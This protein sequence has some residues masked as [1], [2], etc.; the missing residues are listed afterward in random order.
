MAQPLQSVISKTFT[1]MDA[2]TQKKAQTE[3]CKHKLPKRSVKDLE[4]LQGSIPS[5]A[6]PLGCENDGVVKG[7]NE[8]HTN[9]W[10]GGGGGRGTGRTAPEKNTIR[11]KIE[12]FK[13]N[14]EK[15]YWRRRTNNLG[16]LGRQESSIRGS[17][18]DVCAGLQ[19]KL[20]NSQIYVADPGAL[21]RGIWGPPVAG[22]ARGRYQ[23]REAVSRSPK[24]TAG[25]GSP[26]FGSPPASAAELAGLSPPPL[27]PGPGSGKLFQANSAAWGLRPLQAAVL[28]GPAAG[29]RA[30]RR[31][32]DARVTRGRASEGSRPR[33]RRRDPTLGRRR[34]LSAR[35]APVSLR[36]RLAGSARSLRP[37]ARPAAE[38]ATPR[39]SV[40]HLRPAVRAC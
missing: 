26:R 15:L 11:Y 16:S 9:G 12:C 33:L 37:A 20:T 25:G 29:G 5:T 31:V 32:E 3:N 40:P 35:P 34:A 19:L 10:G 38:A 13:I 14:G 27:P 24:A 36:K 8:W 22:A 30:L 39:P 28:S 21:I 17:S 18:D 2:K 6:E 7:E 4:G 23:A 1:Q